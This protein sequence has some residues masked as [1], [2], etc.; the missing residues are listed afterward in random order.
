MTK[1]ILIWNVLQKEFKIFRRLPGKL[2]IR[3]TTRCI[4][5]R[6]VPNKLQLQHQAYIIQFIYKIII[7]NL[8]KLF[9]L[10]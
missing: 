10:L 6:I 5:D 9:L 3:S 7:S 8:Q 4:V 1:I 2:H